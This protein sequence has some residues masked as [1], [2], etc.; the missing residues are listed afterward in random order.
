MTIRLSHLDEPA[1]HAVLLIYSQM[2]AV[3]LQKPRHYKRGHQ[4]ILLKRHSQV[5]THHSLLIS[6]LIVVVFDG[7]LYV[8]DAGYSKLRV[9]NPKV[10]RDAL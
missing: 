5:I 2:L 10:G 8:V 7:I 3:L 4:Q 6:N 1:P 9:H